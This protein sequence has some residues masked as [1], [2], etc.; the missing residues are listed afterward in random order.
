MCHSLHLF[1]TLP[2]S[3]SLLLRS[4]RS[5]AFHIDRWRVWTWCVKT[6]R[7]VLFQPATFSFLFSIL[8]FSSLSFLLWSIFFCVFSLCQAPP[9]TSRGIFFLR[10]TDANNPRELGGS[11][12][13][14]RL[15]VRILVWTSESS[16]FL[17]SVVVFLQIEALRLI[18][19][20]YMVQKL[21]KM[22]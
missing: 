14:D 13:F 21:K 10:V 22:S 9:W 1:I 19:R 4:R 2:S 17:K 16:S 15:P 8:S 18:G 7:I 5:T 20:N 3:S 11:S 6:T 12:P